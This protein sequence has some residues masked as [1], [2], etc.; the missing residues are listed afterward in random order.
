MLKACKKYMYTIIWLI[1]MTAIF[2][3]DMT[4]DSEEAAFQITWITYCCFTLVYFVIGWMI[5][6]FWRETDIGSVFA[7]FDL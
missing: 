7:D 3:F 6:K 5:R 2:A 1:L 4:Q